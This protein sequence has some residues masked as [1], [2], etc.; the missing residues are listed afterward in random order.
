MAFVPQLLFAGFF[1]KIDLI[2]PFLRWVQYLCFLKFAINLALIFEF[3][4]GKCNLPDPSECKEFLDEDNVVEHDWYIYLAIVVGL[5][6][7]FRF[8]ALV[9]L[10]LR[11]SA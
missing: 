1:V 11:A 5:F 9:A 8:L 10:T 6:I 2:P 4:D 7:T 3:G